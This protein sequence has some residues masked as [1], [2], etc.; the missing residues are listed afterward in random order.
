[1]AEVE[2]EGK[3]KKLE[4]GFYRIFWYSLLA[5]LLLALLGLLGPGIFSNQHFETGDKKFSIF[6]HRFNGQG[7]TENL[8]IFISRDALPTPLEVGID[9]IIINTFKIESITPSPQF[10]RVDGDKVYYT[11]QAVPGSDI[12]IFFK[13][14]NDKVGFKRGQIALTNGPSLNI[15]RFIYP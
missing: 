14:Q 6:T 13:G 9:R 2:P 1:M 4:F 12:Q 10:S 3:N 15:W 11:F 7:A 8:E 5:L